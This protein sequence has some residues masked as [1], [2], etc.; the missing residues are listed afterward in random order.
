[1]MSAPLPDWM[2]AV[3]RGCRSLALMNS[4][5]TSAPRAFDAS[6]AWRFSSTSASGMK[7]TQR[8][9]CSLV[10]WAKAGARCAARMPAMPVSW[11]NLRRRIEPSPV[12][13]DP[14]ALV[15]L[16]QLAL[17]PLH[18]VLGLHALDGLGVHVRDDV[19]REAFGRLRRRGAGVA[20]QPRVAG[21]R[22]EHLERLVELA[23][24]GIVLPLVGGADGVALLRGEPLAVVLGLVQPGQEVLGQLRVLAVL[25]DRVRLVQEEQEAAGGT[26]RQRRV[27][28]VLP[29]RLALVVLDLVLLPLG[30]DVDRGAVEGG[31]DLAGVEGA[32][33]VGVVPGQPA[34]VAA[35]LPESLHELHRL[36]RALGV[37]HDFLAALVR[38]G[39]AV[40]PQHRIGED[41][42][43]AEGVAQ[44][45]AVRLALLL[46]PREELAGLVPRLRVLAGA[47][48][49]QPRAAIG[50]RVA[51]DR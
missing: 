45:L 35:L 3:M 42:R 37:Q 29:E 7:S 20:E 28:D 17:G 25:H 19:L 8:T 9:M 2:A 15:D 39:P 34:L 47:G 51:H 40:R 13:S 43:V 31:R 32:V 23:P 5:V 48:L 24:H 49:L 41:G 1:M 50:D 6:G 10:P 44:C 27:I 46:H 18:G 21:G 38:L 12:R 4:S 11:R 36:E 16:L 26:G 22:A 33:V 14:L 30:H